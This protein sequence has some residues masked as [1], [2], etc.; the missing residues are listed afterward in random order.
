M[1]K[2][3]FKDKSSVFFISKGI[4]I[5]TVILTSSI[6]FTL[7][8]FVGKFYRTPS[9]IQTS[10][11]PVKEM[12]SQKGPEYIPGDS[13]GKQPQQAR[14]E[15]VPAETQKPQETQSVKPVQQNVQPRETKS[16][17]TGQKTASLQENTKTSSPK[18]YVVQVGAFK[19]AS[20]AQA[21]MLK[22]D[23]KGYHAAVIMA[24][25][26]NDKMYKVLV[27]EFKTRDE[28]E[29]LAIK[30]KKAEGLKAFVTFKNR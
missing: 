27:G 26:K 23:K 5:L 14:G 6:G 9:E 10:V 28:A 29:I 17:Q 8:F 4:I 22:L 1:K 3:D 2:T 21:L 15:Q 24:K 11:I 19:S 12:P 7:G 25:S 30:I 13:I 20:D 16:A 18:K